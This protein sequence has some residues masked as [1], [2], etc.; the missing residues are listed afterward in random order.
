MKRCL[1]KVIGQ[2]RFSWDELLTAMVEAEGVINSRPLSYVSM[3]DLEE[4]LTPSHLLTGRRL[5]SLP[6]HL[7][8]SPEEEVYD[9]E[10]QLLTKRM[11]H[12]N[13]SLKQF[14][15]RWQKEYLLE[16]RESHRHHRGSANLSQ[17]SVGD[18][19]IVHSTDQPRGFWK[20]GRVKELLVGHDG[21]VQGAVLRV[22]GKGRQATVLRRPIQLLYPLEVTTPPSESEQT[23]ATSNQ[24]QDISSALRSAEVQQDPPLNVTTKPPPQRQSRRAA[25]M[26]ARDRLLAQSLN[27]DL[28][29]H[30]N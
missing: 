2:A 14:W 8:C 4:P 27:S 5:L 26:E 11:R 17:V 15:K 24:E 10:P 23:P 20:L 21:E 6:D 9:V 29:P 30:F 22:A 3:D 16:L 1:R 18:I 19:V 7:C 13:R 12:L 28:N 25:A